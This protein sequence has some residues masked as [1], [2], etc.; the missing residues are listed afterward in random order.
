MQNLLITKKTNPATDELYEHLRLVAPTDFTLLIEGE[1]GT[2]KEHIARHVHDL[3]PRVQKPFIAVD[4]GILSEALASSA[5]FGHIKGA[6][7]GA[8]DNKKGHFELAHGGTLF[9]DEIGNLGYEIQ[10][11]LLRALQERVITPTGGTE[12][13][14]VDVRIIAATNED[15]ISRVETGQFREDLYYRLNE[16]KIKIPPLRD[17][18]SE[19]DTFLQHFLKKTNLELGKNVRRFSEPLLSIL[20]SYNWPGNLR[21]L[22]NAIRRMV[23]LTDGAEIQP[24]TL[25]D[26]MFNVPVDAFKGDTDLKAL[27]QAHEKEWILSTLEEVRYNKSK[28]ARMLSIDRKT[29]YY[30]MEKYGIK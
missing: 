17:R 11:K 27:Q 19:F 5:L 1:S 6:F 23:L 10:V 15:L 21:E 30:K 26:E 4:C 3:S 25:P 2:G 8:S 28:A 29:L 20:R 24:S 9:L 14:Q 12:S 7:T 18:M 13:Y 16:F 22:N